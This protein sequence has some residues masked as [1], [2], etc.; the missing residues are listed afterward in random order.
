[1][2][3]RAFLRDDG[4]QSEVVGTILL[5]ALT[6]IVA[7][8]LGAFVFGVGS[9]QHVAPSASFDF[10]FGGSTVTV[11]HDG[12]DAVPVAD[13]LTTNVTD[14]TLTGQDW[15]DLGTRVETGTSVTLTHEVG[16]TATAWDGET[17]RVTWTSADGKASA[18]L[19][20][21]RAPA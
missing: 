19:A 11:T 10:D 20:S 17:V 6:V 14:G 8:L 21:K 3:L 12:G 4:A 2:H 15:E 18:T 16:G 1:M 13:T 9:S 7:S 5:V